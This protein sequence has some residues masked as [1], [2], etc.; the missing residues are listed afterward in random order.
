MAIVQGTPKKVEDKLQKIIRKFIWEDPKAPISLESLYLSKE[1]GLGLLDIKS[2]NEAIEL[3]WL[4]AYLKL[5]KDRLTWAFLADTLI[6]M[7]I[8][9]STGKLEK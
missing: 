5:M 9:K 1:G 8:L 3:M 7:N 4:K 2:R 6:K